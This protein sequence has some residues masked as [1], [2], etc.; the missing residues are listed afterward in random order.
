MCAAW[1]RSPRLLASEV[2]D[3]ATLTRGGRARACEGQLAR[4]RAA[5]EGRHGAG[6]SAH[7][8]RSVGTLKSWSR[9]SR[10]SRYVM[11]QSSCGL[12]L[13]CTMAA[14]AAQNSVYK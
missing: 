12:D 8:V 5:L 2:R 10:S 4:R 9:G 1:L 11:P 14:G 13:L 6:R 3:L 7:A